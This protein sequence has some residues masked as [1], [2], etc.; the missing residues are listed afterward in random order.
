MKAERK[1]MVRMSRSPALYDPQGPKPIPV[2]VHEEVYFGPFEYV[3][4]VYE[5]MRASVADSSPHIFAQYSDGLWWAVGHANP[6][7]DICIFTHVEDLEKL[8]DVGDEAP[9]QQEKEL[10]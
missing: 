4:M 8:A 7:S 9:A 10:S 5:D 3:E 6:F 1:V 2:S